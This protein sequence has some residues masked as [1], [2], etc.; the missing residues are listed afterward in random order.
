MP[1]EYSARWLAHAVPYENGV[2]PSKCRQYKYRENENASNESICQST[3]FDSSLIMTCD[4]YVYKTDEITILNE[5][6]TK[7]DIL[8]C[9]PKARVLN[10]TNFIFST[11]TQFNMNCDENEWKLSMVG[12]A[13][14][15]AQFIFMPMAGLLSDR[16]GRRAVLMCSLLSS[17]IFGVVRSF[18]S[19]YV[20]FV[21]F[22]FIEAGLGVGTYSAALILG[23]ELVGANR[24]VFTGLLVACS[25]SFGGAFLAI[26]AMYTRNFRTLLRITYVPAFVALFYPLLLPESIRWLMINGYREKAMAI[27]R[28]ATKNRTTAIL[29]ENEENDGPNDAN[30]E[31]SLNEELITDTGGADEQATHLNRDRLSSSTTGSD[32]LKTTNIFNSNVMMIRVAICSACWMTNTFVYFG[33]SLNVVTFDG[34]KYIN[35]ILVVLAEI[36]SIFATYFLIERLGRRW[37]FGGSMLVCGLACIASTLAPNT[38]PAIGLSLYILAKCSITVSFTVLYVYTAEMF[39]TNLRHSLLS[40]CSMVGRIGAIIAPQTPLLVMH[41]NFKCP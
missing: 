24:R 22:E 36:P 15:L 31:A 20:W 6:R 40:F 27:I 3:N 1:T 16:F 28:K 19:S 38:V 11:A 13:N 25:N 32:A 8:N 41:L 29:S 7:N 37:S 21:L 23:M 30:H 2:T 5:V 18:A 17:A 34:N 14:S 39:P 12:S 35:F 10:F 33:L 26:T 9:I 4:E